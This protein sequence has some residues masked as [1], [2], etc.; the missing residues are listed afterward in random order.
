MATLRFR[1][2]K[3]RNRRITTLMRLTANTLVLVGYFVLLNV[4]MTT[5][6]CIRILSA[7]LV[8]PW[9]IQNKVWDGV[10][11]MSIMTSIDI[12]KLFVLLFQ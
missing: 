7:L 10:T 8:L 1:N 5:G 6:I 9:M 3:E 2:R 4:D 12:Q 11:V